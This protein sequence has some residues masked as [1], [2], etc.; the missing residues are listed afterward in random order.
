MMAKSTRSVAFVILI[1]GVAARAVFAITDGKNS[2]VATEYC[3]VFGAFTLVLLFNIDLRGFQKHP[4]VLHH[5][6]FYVSRCNILLS[7]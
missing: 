5:P 4:S 6:V 7:L 3:F 2:Q 1:V